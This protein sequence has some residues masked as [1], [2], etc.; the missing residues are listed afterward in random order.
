MGC[1][2]ALFVL[3]LLTVA[4]YEFKTIWH[5]TAPIGP[6][7]QAIKETEKW[8]AWWRGVL[9]VTELEPGDEIGLGVVHRSVWKSRLPYTLEFDSEVVRLEEH[10][11]I[12]VRAFGELEG[13]GIWQFFE[14][15]SG[16]RAQYDWRV[17][18]TKPWMDLFAPVARP[19]FKWNHDVIMRWGDEGLRKYLARG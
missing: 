8:P 1:H 4:S 14:T 3:G 9:S 6:V 5:Q 18:T 13:S 12:E 15:G 7:W 11:L 16:V 19:F 2:F 17:I 10:R